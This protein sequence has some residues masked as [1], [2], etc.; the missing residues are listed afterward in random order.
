MLG[1]PV[2][3]RLG[4]DDVHLLA[5]ITELGADFRHEAPPLL[6]RV[7]HGGIVVIA[8]FA[9]AANELNGRAAILQVESESVCRI[10]LVTQ[11]VSVKLCDDCHHDADLLLEVG[12]GLPIGRDEIGQTN[13]L[14]AFICFAN[15]FDELVDPGSLYPRSPL[16]ILGSPPRGSSVI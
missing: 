11:V 1:L 4:K 6:I 3:V 15:W 13:S 7:V 8:C 12:G 5:W 10:T 16:G 14:V 2:V 9:P